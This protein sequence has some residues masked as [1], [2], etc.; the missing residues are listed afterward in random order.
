MPKAGVAVAVLKLVRRQTDAEGKFFLRH[1]DSSF[2]VRPQHEEDR[3]RRCR[4]VNEIAAQPAVR[5]RGIELR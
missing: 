3:G 2:Q 1:H 4:F 5:L